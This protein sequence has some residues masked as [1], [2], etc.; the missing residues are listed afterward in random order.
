MGL[1]GSLLLALCTVFLGAQT[2]QNEADRQQGWREAGPAQ[3]GDYVLAIGTHIPL[4]LINS[5]S[6]RTRPKG[7]ACIWRAYSRSW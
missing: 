4:S 3:Q 6:T 5:I 1:R 7:T 2:T